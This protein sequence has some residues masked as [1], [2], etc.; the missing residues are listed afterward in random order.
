LERARQKN[1]K[2]KADNLQFRL[3][4][5]PF[6]GHVPT[7][8]G[9]IL[10]PEKIKAILE[11]PTPTDLTS[12]QR[13]LGMANYLSKFVPKLS[14]HTE[15]LRIL[16]VKDADWRWLPEHEKSCQQ[17]KYLLTCA[18]VLRYYD[19]NLSVTIQCDASDTGLGA[20]HPRPSNNVQLQGT[21]SD[22]T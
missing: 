22:G 1:L 10:S 20:V 16:T 12:L 14:D 6:V 19:V 5:V 2:F 21:H 9:L 13:F 7:P 4:E 15:L 17:L 8:E 3:Q 11:M 18:P